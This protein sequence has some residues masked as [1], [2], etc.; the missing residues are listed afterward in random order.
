MRYRSLLIAAAMLAVLAVQGAPATSAAELSARAQLLGRHKIREELAAALVNGHLSRRDQ[1]RILLDAKGVLSP[2]DLAGLERTLERLAADD[3][4]R[5]HPVAKK[6]SFEGA[7]VAFE[8]A[9]DGKAPAASDLKYQDAAD[10]GP[11][12]ASPTEAV[13]AGPASPCA[14]GAGGECPTEVFGDGGMARERSCCED[15]F[16][17]DLFST[18]DAFKGPMDFGVNGNFGLGLGMN[19]GMALVPEYGIGVQAGSRVILSDFAGEQLAET[20]ASRSQDFTSVGLF[21]RIPGGEGGSFDWGFTYD[22]LFENYYDS[23]RFG[24]WRVK[25]AWEINCWN[26]I[27]IWAAFHEHGAAGEFV[28]PDP[29][30]GQPTTSTFSFRPLDQG[31]LYWRHTWLND[32]S[33]TARIGVANS[34]NLVILGAESRIP[35][36]PHLALIGGFTYMPS[37]NPAFVAGQTEGQSQETWNVSVGV[38]FVPQVLCH[39]LAGRYTPLLPVADN[40][41]MAL[42]ETD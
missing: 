9:P 4:S 34:P 18:V 36:S 35:I 28:A 1:Y 33:V 7:T 40:G 16:D 13:P 6:R 2:E 32:A 38:E 21:Q 41:T 27:G 29:V 11:Q 22:W 5:S 10:R 12:R 19:V 17:Y 3:S 39:G 31:N 24:Q 14:D 20:S 15:T 37:K 25:L 42:K 8:A 30:T 23:V 26:E